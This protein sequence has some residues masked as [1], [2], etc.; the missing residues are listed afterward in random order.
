[1]SKDEQ[2]LLT[3]SEDG[4]ARVWPLAVDESWPKDKFVLKVE[5]ETGT[6]LDAFEELEVIPAPEWHALR[7]EYAQIEQRVR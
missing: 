4:T 3:W 2:R 6:R 7:K 5:V 1:M